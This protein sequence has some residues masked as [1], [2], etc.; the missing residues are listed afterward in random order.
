MNNIK[1]VK[2]G[3]KQEALITPKPG[4]EVAEVKVV[5][6]ADNQ[7]V[8]SELKQISENPAQWACYFE[9]PA[10]HVSIKPVINPILYSVTIEENDMCNIVM[11]EQNSDV[12]VQIK[13]AAI[14]EDEGKKET[15]EET[16]DFNSPQHSV[17]EDAKRALDVEDKEN[18]VTISDDE[19]SSD[20]KIASEPKNVSE[21]TS[22][23][24]ENLETKDDEVQ[25]KTLEEDVET[26]ENDES[27][28]DETDNEGENDV[29]Y[30]A[31]R[32]EEELVEPEPVYITQKEHDANIDLYW[33]WKDKYDAGK[34]SEEEF[35]KI[36]AKY[37]KFQQDISEGLIII[38][39]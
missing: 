30:D 28:E 13:D 27:D 29:Y 20:E 1:G 34:C 26:T 10:G 21:E 23:L 3:T 15:P 8:P 17:N 16:S 37:D 36:R 5:L 9:Q 18:D 33:K 32:F 6:T 25:V 22:S 31:G 19:D 38:C 11:V 4:Y 7:V 39:E 12:D 24:E 14:V 2:V 35:V